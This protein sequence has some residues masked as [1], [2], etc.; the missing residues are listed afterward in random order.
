MTNMFSGA[1]SFN[2]N[3]S[4]WNTSKVTNMVRMF[5]NASFFT[6]DLSAWNVQNVLT[7]NANNIF[8]NCPGMLTRPP[9]Q[10]PQFIYTPIILGC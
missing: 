4:V 5:Q 7:P 8:C 1:A 9:S 10:I 2:Q 6:Q 3:I